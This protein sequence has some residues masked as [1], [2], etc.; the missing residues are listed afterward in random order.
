M[1]QVSTG[2]NRSVLIVSGTMEQVS[3]HSKWDNGTGQ[4]RSVL[5]VSGTMEQVSTGQYSQ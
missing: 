4:Y 1:E 5:T 2:Q 3:T